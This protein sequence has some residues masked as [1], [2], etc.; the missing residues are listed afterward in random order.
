M[1]SQSVSAKAALIEQIMVVCKAN[2]VRDAGDIFLAL[3]FRSIGE[4]KR[5][6]V[7]LH[8]K[9]DATQEAKS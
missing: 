8:I 2:D 7:E 6:A 1:A 4:L 5:I 3:A 9:P